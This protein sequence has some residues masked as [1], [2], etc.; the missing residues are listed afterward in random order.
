MSL[1]SSVQSWE[2]FL[3][4]ALGR[5][6]NAPESMGRNLEKKAMAPGNQ[7][8]QAHGLETEIRLSMNQSKQREEQMLSENQT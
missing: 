3:A 6:H 7:N 8:D 1:D 4:S 2:E 5:W